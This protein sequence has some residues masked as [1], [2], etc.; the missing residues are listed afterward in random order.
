M[1][2]VNVMIVGSLLACC[3]IQADTIKI[4]NHARYPVYVGLYYVKTNLWSSSIAPALLQG[5]L[6]KITEQSFGNLERPSW[7]AY[8]NRELLFSAFEQDLLQELNSDQYIKIAQKSAGFNNGSVYHIAEKDGVLLGYSDIEWIIAKPIIDQAD[9]L[10]YKFLKSLQKYYSDHPYANTQAHVTIG[11]QLI[12]E[13]KITVAQRLNRA[14]DTLEKILQVQIPAEKTPRIAVC[15]SGGGV[16]A[17][18]CAFGLMSGL[19]DCGLLDA[20]SYAS[21]L[22]GSTWFLTDWIYSGKSIEQYYNNFITSIT[23]MHMFGPEELA[24][25]LWCKYIFHQDVSV[26]DAYGVFLGKTFLQHIDNSIDREKITLS[27]LA[28]RIADGSYVYPLCTADETSAEDNWVTFSPFNISSESLKFSIPTWSFGR[29]F[30]EGVSTDFAPE[31]SLGFLMGMWGSALSGSV[32]DILKVTISQLHPLLYNKLNTALAATG[33][34]DMR[35]AGIYVH[36]PLYG[37]EKMSH[38]VRNLPHMTF[39]DAGYISNLPIR[40]LLHTERAVDIIIIID[41]SQDVHQEASELKRAE[42]EI[43]KLSLPFPHIDYEGISQRPMSIFV[44]PLDKR[45]PIV[46]Y[47]IPVKQANFDA[48]FDPAAEFNGTYFTGKFDYNDHDAAN[49]IGLVK[50][51]VATNAD[52]IL[53]LIKMRSGINS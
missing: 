46:V 42:T 35:A 49:L 17:A 25:V 18:M 30:K 20:V 52:K 53:D 21:V 23:H 36:N 48:R 8:N 3:S 45:A 47:I 2:Y 32:E 15:M 24:K 19:A 13:E 33:V 9:K 40:P 43:K 12:D 44:D 14:H 31:P 10:S 4:Y 38:R 28:P 29:E 1:R 16:R 51:I 39:M 22:S 27:S 41:A 7:S 5:S 34:A 26:I 11:G 37:C 50:H 6:V